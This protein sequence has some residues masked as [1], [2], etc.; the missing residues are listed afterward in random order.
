MPF[1]TSAT[2]RAFGPLLVRMSRS[3]VATRVPIT[4]GRPVRALARYWMLAQPRERPLTTSANPRAVLPVVVTRVPSANT[5]M[6]AYVS[7]GPLRRFRA[8]VVTL[9]APASTRLG[10]G[11]S[12]P[13][14]RYRL[15][16]QADGA[17]ELDLGP[18]A[19]PADLG[20]GL[21]AVEPADDR[22]LVLGSA[23]T[24]TL[25]VAVTWTVGAAV[26]GRAT[27]P[28]STAAASATAATRASARP[29]AATLA[30]RI[31]SSPITSITSVTKVTNCA[32][33]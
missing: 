26:A 28:R 29:R 14:L 18:A 9:T 2:V 17:G 31:G 27:S 8:V 33:L 25:A 16:T 19:D 13:R 32:G 12:A 23:R 10:G 1:L 6:T 7:P 24:L 20:D 3:A 11:R 21:A 4:A 22:A 30:L 15:A 5:R